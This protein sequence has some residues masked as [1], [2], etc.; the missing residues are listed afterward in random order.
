V[1]EYVATQLQL[2]LGTSYQGTHT[3]PSALVAAADLDRS[4]TI[5]KLELLFALP[6][7]VRPANWGESI[8]TYITNYTRY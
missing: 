5:S 7:L 2:Q 3:A 1:Y 8:A 6:D 4:G